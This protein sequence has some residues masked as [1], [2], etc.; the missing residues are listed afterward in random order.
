[1]AIDLNSFVLNGV[2]DEGEDLLS[3]QIEQR[4]GSYHFT[5][6][7]PLSIPSDELPNQ[8]R[9]G[10]IHGN[11]LKMIAHQMADDLVDQGVLTQ[12]ASCRFFYGGGYQH[13]PTNKKT[14][15]CIAIAPLLAKKDYWSLKK[16]SISQVN[17]LLS[18]NHTNLTKR[19]IH[20]IVLSGHFIPQFGSEMSLWYYLA[21]WA[22]LQLRSSSKMRNYN[23]TKM[24]NILNYQFSQTTPLR[25]KAVHT[26]DG[27][28][29]GRMHPEYMQN[30]KTTLYKEFKL[31]MV[32]P[33]G[34]LK[35]FFQ[36]HGFDSI[37]N[38]KQIEAAMTVT[39]C[40]I[41]QN[42]AKL[43]KFC[44]AQFNLIANNYPNLVTNHNINQKLKINTI[45]LNSST[46]N[47]AILWY[48]LAHWAHW[49]LTKEAMLPPASA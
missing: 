1:M 15:M 3:S 39:L 7:S 48:Y 40:M 6:G 2:N 26:S 44:T 23:Q 11:Y 4:A 32:M 30:F 24:P 12:Q 36:N 42:Y 31:S 29:P 38:I 22:I 8:L 9:S 13:I 18:K 20:S 37:S 46:P 21:V 41:N 34:V 49:S 27:F 28:R 16:L 14:E 17:C 33:S 35:Y 25:R 10:Y 45:T 43:I 5:D 19:Q 47:E